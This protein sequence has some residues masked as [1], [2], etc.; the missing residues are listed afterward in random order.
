MDRSQL[1]SLLASA[2]IGTR[3]AT[4]NAV[5]ICCP[6]CPS[7]DTDYHCGV[8]LNNLRFN[9]WRCRSTGSL[10][11]LL[12]AFGLD[13]ATIGRALAGTAAIT[14]HHI[15][16]LDRVRAALGGRAGQTPDAA[17]PVE[18]P[19]SE[20]ID[21]DVIYRAPALKGFLE[22]R[23]IS[24]KTCRRYDAR[25]GGNTGDHVHRIV[26]PVYGEDGRLVAWQSRDTTGLAHTKYLTGGRASE[27]LYWTDLAFSGGKLPRVYVVEGVFDAWRIG[28]NTVAT[29]S[30]AMSQSQRRL[31]LDSGC[32][33]EVVMAWDGDSYGLSLAAAREMAPLVRA[34]A[35]RLPDGEDPDSLGREKIIGLEVRW[36]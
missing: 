8:F 33:Q 19:P 25:W 30:H 13:P 34:G 10:R 6:L 5:N 29:F 15:P 12:E 32:V 17:K 4:A 7:P 26:L 9:C 3:R 28:T 18:L 1:E 27:A 24:T 14:D 16:L 2:R 21:Q 22:R 35:V 20:P 23:R 31:L 11:R 36:V